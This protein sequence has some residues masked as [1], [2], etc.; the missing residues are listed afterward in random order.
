MYISTHCGAEAP[1]APKEVKKPLNLPFLKPLVAPSSMSKC[2]YLLGADATINAVN[3]EYTTTARMSYTTPTSQTPPFALKQSKLASNDEALQAHIDRW[4]RAPSQVAVDRGNSTESKRAYN[5]FIP[6]GTVMD[7]KYRPGAIF[8]CFSLFFHCFPIILSLF[9]HFCHC[10]S[11]TF[12]I[13]L[14]LFTSFSLRRSPRHLA[15]NRWQR[16]RRW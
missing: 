8:H 5:N 2:T 1:H 16:M 4:T 13:I 10:F 3:V 6:A 11:I 7:A 9:H 14:S 15:L 12:P